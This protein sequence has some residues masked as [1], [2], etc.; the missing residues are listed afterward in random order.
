M[1]F[2]V[3]AVLAGVATVAQ[4]HFQLQ[5]PEPRGPF[6]EDDEPT[7]CDG[8]AQA[9]SNRT[10]FPLSGGFF[11]LN[12]EH[13]T[14]NVAVLI[15]TA[16]DPASFNDFNNATGGNQLAKNFVSAQGEGVFC[17]PLDLSHT[18]VSGVADGANVTIQVLFNGG[19]GSLYQCADLTLSSTASISAACSNGTSSSSSASASPSATSPASGSSGAP[20]AS[21]PSTSTST[22][23]NGARTLAVASSACL[24]GAI[25]ALALAL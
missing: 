7:F 1:R 12:S 9:V 2:A 3:A 10:T 14:W 16:Q 25:V 18:G 17:L 22:T 11:T 5:F 4:A 24:L 21:A 23:P 19:D 15:S 20:S 6:V 13:P 8:Y